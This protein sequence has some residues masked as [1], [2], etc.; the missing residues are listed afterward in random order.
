MPSCVVLP[1]DALSAYEKQGNLPQFL[2]RLEYYR[3]RLGAV[4]IID[5]GKIPA[6]TKGKIGFAR[7]PARFPRPWNQ[8]R[9]LIK[10]ARGVDFI[11]VFEGGTFTKAFAGVLASKA[12][13]KPLVVSLHGHHTALAK[14]YG[15]SKWAPAMRVAEWLLAH[16]GALVLANSRETASRYRGKSRV[17]TLYV[18]TEKFKPSNAKKKYD[19]VYVGSLQRVKNIDGLLAFIRAVRQ[20]VPRATLAVAG[21]G[22]LASKLKAPGVSYL[23]AV[24]HDALPRVYAS[25]RAFVTLTH[26]ESFGIPVIEAQ[27]CG[28]PSFARPVGALRENTARSSFLGDERELV[29][30]A[31]RLLEKGDWTARGAKARAFVVK[32]YSR[33]AVLERECAAIRAY[34]R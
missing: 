3:E 29:D 14:Y 9:A 28:L 13:G 16:S 26:Y 32:K 20:R 17:S 8:A 23:G 5:W 24:P 22:P 33:G 1:N 18:D 6:K 2:D 21:E 25:A 27:A 15:W 7:E 11:R 19:F 12:T 10:H 31:V 4:T 30:A 34:L